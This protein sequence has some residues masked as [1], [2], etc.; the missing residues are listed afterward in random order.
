MKAGLLLIINGV[1]KKMGAVESENFPKINNRDCYWFF[2]GDE[3][4]PC[5]LEEDKRKP[6]YLHVPCY[7]YVANND[8]DRYIRK[9]LKENEQLKL[10]KVELP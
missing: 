10:M 2:Y 9:L 1:M 3:E 6:C 7:Y 5:C 8:T 4:N